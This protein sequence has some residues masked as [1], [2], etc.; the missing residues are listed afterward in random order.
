MKTFEEIQDVIR[1]INKM[2]ELF[3]S[4]AV[5]ASHQA[6]IQRYIELKDHVFEILVKDVHQNEALGSEE[7]A[8]CIDCDICWPD[9]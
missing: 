5:V 9:R 7:I 8:D 1:S 3:R 2:E 6:Q 4:I